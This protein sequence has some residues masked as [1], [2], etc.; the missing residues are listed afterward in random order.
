[1]NDEWGY[2]AQHFQM[3]EAFKKLFLL[4]TVLSFFFS[5]CA[6]TKNRGSLHLDRELEKIF[7][8]YQ[9]LP[10]YNYYTSGG[11]DKPNAIL[12]VH[13][14]YQMVTD[15]WVSIPNVNSA[16]IEKWIR[17]IDPEDRSSGSSFYAYYI[18]DPEGNQV[19]FWYSIENFTVIKFLEEN[20]I[21]VY[22]PDLIQP[23]DDF[24]GDGR[25][26]RIKL[27]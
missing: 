11:Y 15:F 12:G 19:G 21:D 27:R 2:H 1:M 26:M 22:P 25:G 14:D 16:Q 4:I 24:G 20:K 18:L 13:K 3:N 7:L 10:D 9:V 8:S 17:T 5:G 23:G 6:G